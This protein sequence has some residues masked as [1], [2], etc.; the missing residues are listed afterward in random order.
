MLGIDPGVARMGY[1]AVVQEGSKLKALDYGTFATEAG[2]PLEKRLAFL[3]GEL[4]VVLKKVKP[5][6]GGGRGIVF[7]PQR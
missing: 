5:G 3:F 4:Q 7:F 1:G 2:E 6:R